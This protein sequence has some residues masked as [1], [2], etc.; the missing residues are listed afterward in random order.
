MKKVEKVLKCDF[1]WEGKNLGETTKNF[2]PVIIS[3]WE[4]VFGCFRQNN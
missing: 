1:C 2:C 3:M 4:G